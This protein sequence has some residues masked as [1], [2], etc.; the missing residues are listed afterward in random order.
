ERKPLSEE[1]KLKELMGFNLIVEIMA[2]ASERRRL[3]LDQRAIPFVPGC[4]SVGAL[5]GAE[6]RVIIEPG[7]VLFGEGFEGTAKFC[8]S[9]TLVTRERFVQ[10]QI[11]DVVCEF[12]VDP[13]RWRRRN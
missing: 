7:R 2:S 4:V 6:E 8:I 12:K 13:V 3:A 5:E 1:K 9:R 11:L 10:D